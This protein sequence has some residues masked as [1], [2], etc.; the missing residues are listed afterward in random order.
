MKKVLFVIVGAA[1]L[2]F[3]A[4]CGHNINVQGFG[5]ACPYGAMGYGTFSCV[6]DNV[7]VETTENTTKDGVKTTNKFVVGKQTTGYDVEIEAVKAKK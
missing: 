6:K 5:I 4:G 1:S 2:I 7:S 3:V